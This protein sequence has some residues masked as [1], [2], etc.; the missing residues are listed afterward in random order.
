M[1]NAYKKSVNDVFNSVKKQNDEIS[2]TNIVEIN[3][4]EK[5]DNHTTEQASNHTTGQTTKQ[6]S[7][8][9]SEQL[10]EQ[11]DNH[12]NKQPDNHTTEHTT[13]QTSKHKYKSTTEQTSKHTTTQPPN[14]N[15]KQFEVLRYIYFNRPFKVKGKNGLEGILNMKY[16]N[17]RNSLSSLTKKGYIEKPFIV[18]NSC[19]NGSTCRVNEN[20]CFALFGKTNI[21]QPHNRTTE[22]SIT[23]PN[24]HINNHTT[25]QSHNHTITQPSNLYISSSSS[26]KP[27]TKINNYNLPE[28]KFWIETGIT[29]KQ[30]CGWM[31][32]FDITEQSMLDFLRYAEFDLIDN[33]KIDK[34]PS[35]TGWF[36]KTLEKNHSYNKPKNFKSYFDKKIEEEELNNKKLQEQLNELK[37]KREEGIALKAEIWFYSLTENEQHDVLK[38]AKGVLANRFKKDMESKSAKAFIKNYYKENQI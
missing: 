15:D 29:E 4:T 34:V 26:K 25:E 16:G 22:Q 27:T 3:K 2:K 6:V 33:K 18:Y 1:L 36:F 14:L 5:P 12:T 21:E 19:F 37:I 13:E 7:E 8:Q 31:N 24:N 28:F 20:I 23:Q 32:E 11:P 10:L 35:P 17:V 30:I 38:T 9:V